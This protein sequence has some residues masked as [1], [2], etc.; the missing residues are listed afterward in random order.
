MNQAELKK[1][2]GDIYYEAQM[3]NAAY[4][5]YWKRESAARK[6]QPQ[7][8]HNCIIEATLVH[9]R[10]LLEFFE[11]PRKPA[12]GRPPHEDD[13]LAE[14]YGFAP[15]PFSLSSSLRKRINTSIAHLSYGRARIPDDERHWDFVGF[16]PLIL[17]RSAEFFRHLL[18]SGRP[19]SSY[20]GDTKL[21]EF[22]AHVVKARNANEKRIT[23]TD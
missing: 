11:R 14:D 8:V 6:A 19:C 21:K 7:W 20:P 3:L 10:A 18:D 23:L 17:L 2:T 5:N 4:T 13:V 22:I 16:I 12:T 9:T 1:A 15:A